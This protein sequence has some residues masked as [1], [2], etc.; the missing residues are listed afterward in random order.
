[1]G[2]RTLSEVG[3]YGYHQV[4]PQHRLWIW[5]TDLEQA[6]RDLLISS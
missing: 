5:V 2:L 1:V 3:L 4:L 6:R